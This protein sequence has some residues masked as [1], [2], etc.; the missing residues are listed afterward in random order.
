MDFEVIILHGKRELKDDGTIKW[1]K[2]EKRSALVTYFVDQKTAKQEVLR[3][4][5]ALLK[6]IPNK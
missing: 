5:K 6:Q 1:Q 2:Q 3:M 4:V